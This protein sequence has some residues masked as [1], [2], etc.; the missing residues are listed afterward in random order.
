M[1]HP[2]PR[3]DSLWQTGLDASSPLICSAGRTGFYIDAVG[4]Y[5]K[6]GA[7]A[8]TCAPI[9]NIL[10][11]GEL[12]FAASPVCER[13]PTHQ[14]DPGAE[15]Q[16]W[17]VENKVLDVTKAAPR[18]LE[19]LY[20][21]AFFHID[22]SRLCNS[23]C[24][25][26]TV[27]A[28]IFEARNLA[29]KREHLSEWAQ[30]AYMDRHD[31]ELIAR[32][33][34]AKCD[35][36]VFRIAGVMEPLMNPDI[37]AFFEACKANIDKVREIR[38]MSNL[39]IEKTFETILEM[40]FGRKLHT[41][42]SMHVVDDNFD[43]FR[44]VRQ[45]KR[46]QEAGTVIGSH[47]VP[48][49]VVREVM[50]DYMDFFSLHGVRVRP[51]PHILDDPSGQSLE[52]GTQQ[53]GHVPRHYRA[54]KDFLGADFAHRLPGKGYA[55][56]VEQIR[57]LN[58]DTYEVIEAF[59]NGGLKGQGG[60]VA[61]AARR[62]IFM[63]QAQPRPAASAP[64]PAPAPSPAPAPVADGFGVGELRRQAMLAHATGQLDRAVDLLKQALVQ[65]PLD[66]EVLCDLASMALAGGEPVA[67]VTLARRA[68]ERAPD[69][70]T[71]LYTLGMALAQ[72]G[73]HAP[74]IRA[75]QR[76]A[77]GPGAEALR[78]DAG[79][80]ADRVAPMLERLRLLEAA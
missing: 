79:A 39:G 66:H 23:S 57:R 10:R 5:W 25:Y 34:F 8:S 78:A 4:D 48:S 32:E 2:D 6:C 7:I 28:P 49:P 47:I 33:I 43:P 3:V 51:V 1:L 40:G 24:H 31:L 53:P 76:V 29:K 60:G 67:A 59:R 55:A 27:S 71:S 58:A 73:A 70:A 11:D 16:C 38:L 37:L 68:L 9:G 75:L 30:K 80:L 20:D 56:Y 42:V 61:D 52:K 41:I 64:A 22:V 46:A 72:G 63:L 69:H 36:V 50:V 62:R 19:T 15:I 13:F 12:K 54:M 14:V 65:S 17:C 18:A 35:K 44:V 74:A 45:I 77:S 26:G 21:S